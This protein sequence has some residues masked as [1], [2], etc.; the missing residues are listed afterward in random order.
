MKWAQEALNENEERRG[1]WWG[2]FYKQV[3]PSWLFVKIL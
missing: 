3:C 1:R 2:Q